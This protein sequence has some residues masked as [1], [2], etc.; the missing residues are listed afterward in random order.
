MLADLDLLLTMVFY[1]A[2][3]LLPSAK[4]N[5]R[6]ALTDAEVV[7]LLVAQ[8]IMGISSDRRFVKVARKQ[9][10]RPDCH[11]AR[12][13]GQSGLH[14]RRAAP[15]DALER[16]MA[17]L[18]RECPGFWDDLVL[19]DST[20]VEC[21]RSRETVKRGGASS[22]D[23]AI[24]NAAGYGYCRSHSRFFYGMRLHAAFGPDGT[25]RALRL[26]ADVALELLPAALH[27][28]EIV[29]ADKGYAG[30][31]F[32]AAVTA[33]GAS[34]VRPPR[35]DEPDS[36]PRIAPIRQ[37][38]E[39][40]FWTAKDLLTLERHGARTLRNLRARILQRLLALTACVYLNHWLGRPSRAL[41]DYVA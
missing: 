2:D 4:A 15:A 38:I 30:R 14:K 24:A 8:S 39:S 20:P 26:T 6:R 37:R 33:I 11:P 7:T 31:Q 13:V 5:A 9:R 16:V 3:N 29:I 21:A 35:V 18:A 36:G 34:V 27:G 40:I 28:G 25:P 32:A 22:L 10:Q 19:L 12:L 41:V 17:A 1:T 23:D